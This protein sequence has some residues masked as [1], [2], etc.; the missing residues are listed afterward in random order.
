[1]ASSGCSPKSDDALPNSGVTVRDS[2]EVKIVHNHEMAA[3]ASWSISESP[4]VIIDGNDT[5]NLF[6]NVVGAGRLSDGR[7]AIMNGKPVRIS[8]HGR[9]GTLYR[10][11]GGSGGGPGEFRAPTKF[12]VLSGDIITA[13]DAMHGP[14]Y[15]FDHDGKL[16]LESYV[17]LAK[18]QDAIG[19][20]LH[21][22]TG[23]ALPGVGTLVKLSHRG[24]DDHSP[25]QRNSHPGD[26]TWYRW[27]GVASYAIVTSSYVMIPVG[28]YASSVTSI[29]QASGVLG[30]WVAPM[31]F[32]LSYSAFAESSGEVFI[33]D[34][35]EYKIDVF[36]AQGVMK[37]SVRSDMR[38]TELS[39]TDFE[40]ARIQWKSQYVAMGLSDQDLIDAVKV[41]PDP[42]ML[43]PILGLV[44]DVEGHL[45]VRESLERWS[46]FDPSGRWIASLDIPM[47]KVFEVGSDY[48][49]GLIKDEDGVES[50]VEY[51]LNRQKE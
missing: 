5:G 14:G 2:A 3:G 47:Y 39:D 45:W 50:V 17:D 12:M 40:D 18:L 9:S 51:S 49:V 27:T 28:K 32:Y 4:A 43:P 24:S 10:S 30:R 7:I 34:A 41:L 48:I 46:V 20:S 26:G 44:A 6:L 23:A 38:P 15:G 42:R 8:I 25:R 19:D 13:W 1:M 31:Y 22:E 35:L 21:S 33:S 16:V 11:F 36:D 37:R 29:R